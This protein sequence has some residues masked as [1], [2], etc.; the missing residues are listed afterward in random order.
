MSSRPN[1]DDYVDVAARIASFKESFPEG[2]LQSEIVKHTDTEVVVKAYAY[3]TQDDPRP[4]IGHAREVV[5][6]RTPFTKDS[7]VMVAE[8]S[9]W[10]RAIAALG[11]EVRKGIATR[12]EVQAAQ[13]RQEA[14]VVEHQ[15]APEPTAPTLTGGHPWENRLPKNVSAIGAAVEIFKDNLDDK[16]VKAALENICPDHKRD[17]VHRSGVSSKTGKPYA[18]WSCSGKTPEGKFCERRPSIEWQQAHE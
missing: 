18:F 13:A 15:P 1:L 8:T 5:P 17:W 16:V 7:E 3:R 9:A 2:S 11:F 10:G 12:E 4:G 14:P 6:G